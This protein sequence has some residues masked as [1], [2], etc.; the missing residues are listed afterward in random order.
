[1]DNGRTARQSMHQ[2]ARVHGTPH[3]EEA[4]P[5]QELGRQE[6]MTEHGLWDPVV[7]QD[8]GRSKGGWLNAIIVIVVS[9]G[10]G[11]LLAHALPGHAQNLAKGGRC[12]TTTH[13]V[14]DIYGR[15]TNI[16]PDACY[17]GYPNMKVVLLESMIV[18]V[19]MLMTEKE[20]QCPIAR[21]RTV[22]C[23]CGRN[24]VQEEPSNLGVLQQ[25]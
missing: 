23:G 22:R 20:E 19:R 17:G 5:V 3:D 6:L 11:F 8:G 2:H 16:P 18:G 1:M 25:P 7:D 10:R 24:H 12:Y 4:H 9:D 14:P 15:S 21:T 13:M